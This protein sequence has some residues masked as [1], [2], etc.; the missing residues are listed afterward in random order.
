MSA[1]A[2]QARM[3]HRQHDRADLSSLY[4]VARMFSRHPA[5]RFEINDDVAHIYRTR[6]SVTEG[7]S[8]LSIVSLAIPHTWPSKRVMWYEPL[9]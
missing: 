5:G 6:C 3:Y 9:Q 7:D 1:E 2:A 4:S 8:V